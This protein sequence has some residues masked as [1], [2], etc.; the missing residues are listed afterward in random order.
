MTQRRYEQVEPEGDRGAFAQLL[1]AAKSGDREAQDALV[2]RVYPE[3]RR[4]VHK[5]LS[6]SLR[7]S[8]PELSALFS[9]GDVV[10]DVL[11]GVL[12]DLHSFKGD[13]QPAL[14]QYLAVRVSHQLID[15]IRFHQAKCRDRRRGGVDSAAHEPASTDPSPTSA[16]AARESAAALDAAIA[17]LPE[18]L[19]QVLELRYRRGM[20]HADV[21]AALGFPSAEAARKAERTA[22]AQ[23][24]VRM[25]ALG[26]GGR[27]E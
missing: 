25:R 4:L 26:D 27:A 20:A 21:A 19:R 22:R 3:V 14:T 17:T 10:H 11:L 18:R 13:D 8:R 9:T 15:T 12:R 23:L 2:G 16:A 24:S 5:E 6:Q 1:S 7:R